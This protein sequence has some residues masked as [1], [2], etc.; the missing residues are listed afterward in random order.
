MTVNPLDVELTQCTFSWW[1]PEAKDLTERLLQAAA[2]NFGHLINTED[3]E[4]CMHAQKGM[5]SSAYHQGRYNADQEKCL[6]HFHRLVSEHMRPH[7]GGTAAGGGAN[8]HGRNGHGAAA[9]GR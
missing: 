1:F 9:G 7:L 8:G 3:V 6:H 4:I 5:R 2:V